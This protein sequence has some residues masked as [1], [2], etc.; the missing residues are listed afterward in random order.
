M[1]RTSIEIG[2]AEREEEVR[3]ELFLFVR[4]CG[5]SPRM[6]TC[7]LTDLEME[8]FFFF[9]FRERNF[10][11]AGGPFLGVSAACCEVR[12]GERFILLLSSYFFLGLC[13][14]GFVF[15]FVL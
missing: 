4:I 12:E 14:F 11:G 3:G 5:P 13:V 9:V 8:E 7:P 6:L 15:V 1:P 10:E 2:E